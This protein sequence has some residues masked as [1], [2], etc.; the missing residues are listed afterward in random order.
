MSRPQVEIL[1]HIAAPSKAK[2][3]TSYRTLAGA[4][5]DFQPTT[6][7]SVFRICDSSTEA[8]GFGAASQHLT[9][10]G[11]QPPINT[12]IHSSFQQARAV[13]AADLVSPQLSFRSVQNNLDSP[14]LHQVAEESRDSQ[15]SWQPPPSVVPDSYPESDPL[16]P[17]FC[18]PTRILEHFISGWN[19][20][21]VDSSPVANRRVAEQQLAFRPSQEGSSET[22][23]VSD[24]EHQQRDGADYVRSTNPA[25]PAPSSAGTRLDDHALTKSCREAHVQP[26]SSPIHAAT[27]KDPAQKNRGPTALLSPLP[28]GRS[29]WPTSHPKSFPAPGDE[30]GATTVI[31]RSPVRGNKRRLPVAQTPTTCADETRITSYYPSQEDSSFRVKSEPPPA[32]KRPRISQKEPNHG[33]GLA[34]S[35]SDIDPRQQKAKAAAQ[36][37]TQLISTL[38]SEALACLDTLEIFSPAPPTDLRDVDP[39]DMVT[40]PLAKLAGDFNL[41]ARFKPESQTRQLRPFERGYWTVDCRS[42]EASLKQSCWG[43]LTGYLTKGNAGWGVWCGRDSGFTGMRLWC[44]GHVVGHIY[45]LL[46][47]ASQRKLKITGASWLGADNEPVIVVGARSASNG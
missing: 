24:N 13:E 41:Q 1:V 17:G 46:Y 15:S 47:V 22:S 43:F 44:F 38:R 32:A 25:P 18:S 14:R 5:L 35:S 45:L 9:E 37:Q 4:Y 21:E 8:H 7:A 33:N 39:T 40:G 27:Q 20:S 19:R 36:E 31:P 10:A 16:I 12:S 2:D 23:T 34:R 11:E 42:W 28:S 3:D 6:R 30:G 26:S 29:A